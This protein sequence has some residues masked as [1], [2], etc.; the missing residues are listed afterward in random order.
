MLDASTEPHHALALSRRAQ[1]EPLHA[2]QN[3]GA[4]EREIVDVVDQADRHAVEPGIAQELEGVGD[5]VGIDMVGTPGVGPVGAEGQTIRAGTAVP[6]TL[7][8]TPTIARRIVPPTPLSDVSDDPAARGLFEKQRLTARIRL[9]P[10][11]GDQ[12]V[13]ARDADSCGTTL[14]AKVVHGDVHLLRVGL[15]E[16]RAKAILFG[17][18]ESWTHG[19]E[20]IHALRFDRTLV[21]AKDAAYLRFIRFDR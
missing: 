13:A 15:T 8:S 17:G 1:A 21:G 6:S 14:H 10:A 20:E 12:R 5:V 18:G 3:L 9:S 11:A 7:T 16:G 2:R 4:E 19:A